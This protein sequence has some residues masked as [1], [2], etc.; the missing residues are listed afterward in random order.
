V[1]KSRLTLFVFGLMF[2]FCA[3]AL[4]GEPGWKLSS[5]NPFSKQ[6]SS[7]TSRTISDKPKSS[8]QLPKF[9]LKPPKIN[10]LP[11]W[12]QTKTSRPSGPT[13]WDKFTDGTKNFVNK[14]KAT[15]ASPLSI[16]SKKTGR[17]S[18]GTTRYLSGKNDSQPEKK[19]LF[20]GWLTPKKEVP[21]RR[22]APHEFLKLPRPEF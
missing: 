1:N 2:A 20:T 3:S 11:K 9:N 15:L 19:S 6:S 13:A 10:L 21:K 22:T 8:W 14:T 16:V 12:D 5:L 17:S 7:S 18:G 4:A